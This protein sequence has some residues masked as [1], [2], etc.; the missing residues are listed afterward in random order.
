MNVVVSLTRSQ[1]GPRNTSITAQM[2]KVGIW[3][4]NT[5]I[6]AKTDCLLSTTSWQQTISLEIPASPLISGLPKLPMHIVFLC[7]QS[8]CKYIV[9]K[10]KINDGK[11]LKNTHVVI[12][13]LSFN[14]LCEQLLFPISSVDYVLTAKLL[15]YLCCCLS[16]DDISFFLSLHLFVF[17]CVCCW[18][19]SLA[20][21]SSIS[22]LPVCV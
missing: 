22:S 5:L 10:M 15:L 13:E 9:L 2:I 4:E 12:T 1:T 6:K 19:C 8:S 3:R 14:S 21:S 20:A 16:G 11:L 17:F 7:S 18:F